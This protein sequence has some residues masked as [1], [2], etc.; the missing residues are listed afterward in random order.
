MIYIYHL[1]V[2]GTYQCGCE[3]TIA[4]IN[5]FSCTFFHKLFTC[6]RLCVHG[7]KRFHSVATVYVEQLSHRSETVSGINV[8]TMLHVVI[9]TPP[10]FI[11]CILLPV[12]IP[13]RRQTMAV[14]TRNMHYLAKNSML[15]H[16]KSIHFVPIVY[17]VLKKHA[18]FA[19]TLTKIY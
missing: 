7:N 19:G 13:K 18:V 10:Q 6:I 11:I 1:A 3:I 14:S 16:I 15:C 5:V 9:Q 12:Y 17:A 4:E 8:S 2:F